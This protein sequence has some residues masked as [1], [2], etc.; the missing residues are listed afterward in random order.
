MSTQLGFN[1]RMMIRYKGLEEISAH[2]F[3]QGSLRRHDILIMVIR[4]N[5]VTFSH[6]VNITIPLKK[7]AAITL[8]PG[9]DNFEGNLILLIPF[10]S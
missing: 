6:N 4:E 5:A 8:A 7:Y 3:P 10:K 9:I 1:T 2:A